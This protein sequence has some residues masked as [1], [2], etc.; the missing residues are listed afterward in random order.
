MSALTAI[1]GAA[2]RW[3][4]REYYSFGS[5]TVKENPNPGAFLLRTPMTFYSL[6]KSFH[7]LLG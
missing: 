3:M 2:V 1:W 7:L 4:E 5:L 6:N